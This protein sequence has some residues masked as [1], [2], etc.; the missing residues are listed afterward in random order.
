MGDG[1]G[2]KWLKALKSALLLQSSIPSIHIS[3]FRTAQNSS[4]WESN[5]SHLQ[6]LWALVLTQTNDV[7]GNSRVWG[8]ACKACTRKTCSKHTGTAGVGCGCHTGKVPLC[9]RSMFLGFQVGM[10]VPRPF[11]ST[12]TNFFPPKKEMNAIVENH[13][14]T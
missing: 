9:D 7:S 11:P 5:T 2:E 6:P 1:T 3:W 14:R 12:N 13:P 10:V 8:V 4:S